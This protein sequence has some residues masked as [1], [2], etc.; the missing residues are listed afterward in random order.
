MTNLTQQHHNG[1]MIGRLTLL[2]ILSVSV[3]LLCLPVEAGSSQLLPPINT[4]TPYPTGQATP[5]RTPTSLPEPTATPIPSPSTSGAPR[6]RGGF[7]QL[8]VQFSDDWPWERIHWQ[9]L[10]TQVQWQDTKGIWHNT[11]GWYG[12]L[13]YIVD[14]HGVKTWWVPGDLF[15]QGP[16]RWVVYEETERS[17][18]GSSQT[19]TLPTNT[20]MTVEVPISLTP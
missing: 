4:Q 2:V 12:G 8:Q 11:T 9:T 19:F 10:R 5:M 15:G 7:I 13:N 14:L 20:G 6:F 18:L 17:P 1:S 16:F 3:G